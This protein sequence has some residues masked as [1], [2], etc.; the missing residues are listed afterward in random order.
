MSYA[1]IHD[2]C[3]IRCSL[4]IGFPT[5]G[6]VLSEV[7]SCKATYPCPKQSVLILKSEVAYKSMLNMDNTYVMRWPRNGIYTGSIQGDIRTSGMRIVSSRSRKFPLPVLYP[8]RCPYGSTSRTGVSCVVPPAQPRLFPPHRQMPVLSSRLLTTPDIHKSIRSRSPTLNVSKCR[9]QPYDH[10]GC[11]SQR[12]RSSVD[13]IL[14]LR[15]SAQGCP[16]LKGPGY[17]ASSLIP[18]TLTEMATN[19]I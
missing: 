16:G 13:K 2:L 9:T 5:L 17:A 10:T 4:L 11:P 12:T 7:N 15:Y 19:K 6:D 1:L 8:E 18:L 3:L 14:G